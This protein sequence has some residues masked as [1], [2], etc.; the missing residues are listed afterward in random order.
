MR[1]L[2]L[3]AAVAATL[4]LDASWFAEPGQAADL[5]VKQSSQQNVLHRRYHI[6]GRCPDQLSC[7]PLYGAYG[8]YGGVGYWSAYSYDEGVSFSS[9]GTH[10]WG[11]GWR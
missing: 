1:R 3:L 2:F 4:T 9:V 8:P 5:S 11:Y 10:Y 7:W 6:Y